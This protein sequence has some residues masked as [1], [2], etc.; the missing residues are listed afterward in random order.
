[1][2]QRPA[3]NKKKGVG[4]KYKKN[5]RDEVD[6]PPP[7]T[8][9]TAS[10]G[11]KKRRQTMINKARDCPSSSVPVN[12]IRILTSPPCSRP[13]TPHALAV[14]PGPS[15]SFDLFDPS[16]SA[17]IEA[18]LVAVAVAVAARSRAR[19]SPSAG[20]SSSSPPSPRRGQSS[21]CAPSPSYPG[22]RT[23][24][25]PAPRLVPS[26]MVPC[27]TLSL[28]RCAALYGIASSGCTFFS[29]LFLCRPGQRT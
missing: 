27:R 15:G 4:K 7:S 13:E 9:A 22:P 20:P 17:A 28:T 3:A 29:S 11:E 25:C 26:A 1:M 23:C 12:N 6:S 19:T 5:S 8:M 10:K 21:P 14:A 2:I 18:V 16:A 24:T